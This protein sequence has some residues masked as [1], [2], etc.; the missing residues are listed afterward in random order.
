MAKE[1]ISEI[2]E[3]LRNATE[4]LEE[5]REKGDEAISAYDLSMGY[6]AN[7]YLNVSPMLEC[8]VDYYQRQL[9]EALKHGEQLKL[10]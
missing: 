9:D 2:R 7:F 6:D 1:S 3:L 4:R 5:V 10:L 8:H